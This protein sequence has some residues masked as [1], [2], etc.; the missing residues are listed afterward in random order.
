MT[1]SGLGNDASCRLGSPGRSEPAV[2]RAPHLPLDQVAGLR[3]RLGGHE[4]LV[5]AGVVV[6]DRGGYGQ[7]NSLRV[8]RARPAALRPTRPLPGA[9]AWRAMASARSAGQPGNSRV[10][11]A[12]IAAW[13]SMS[14]SA[15]PASW[16]SRRRARASPSAR[17]SPP[18]GRARPLRPGSPGA[19]S[20]PRPFHEQQATDCHAEHPPG[21]AG[22]PSSSSSRFVWAAVRA[23]EVACTTPA[24]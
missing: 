3:T 6:A 22:S 8:E 10:I 7:L 12:A 1:G 15:R 24:F 11:L 17:H 5:I 20:N 2:E 23:V 16:R 19:H 21:E 9:P 13:N 18:P 4:Q 14:R